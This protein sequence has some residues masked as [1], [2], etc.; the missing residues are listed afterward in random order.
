MVY[1]FGELNMKQIADLAFDCTNYASK[2][3]KVSIRK[4]V[5]Q[6]G[7]IENIF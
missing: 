1:L 5:K 6:F 7:F 2:L 3:D 4:T